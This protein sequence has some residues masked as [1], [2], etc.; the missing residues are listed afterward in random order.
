MAEMRKL[1]EWLYLFAAADVD[2]PNVIPEDLRM[3]GRFLWQQEE[4]NT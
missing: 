2:V 4:D 3:V 1:A